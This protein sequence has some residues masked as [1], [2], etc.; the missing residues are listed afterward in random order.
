RYGEF[1]VHAASFGWAHVPSG[2]ETIK[3][4]SRL[5]G[6]RSVDAVGDST[7]RTGAEILVFWGAPG[8]KYPPSAARRGRNAARLGR[9]GAFMWHFSPL[10]GGLCRVR[11][12]RRT[13]AI[14]SSVAY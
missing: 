10:R 7:L 4:N 2:A 3:G 14:P 6:R 5:W 13:G 1:R 9:L 11:R 8:Q 12:H